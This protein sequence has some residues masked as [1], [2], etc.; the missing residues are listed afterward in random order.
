MLFCVSGESGNGNV[1]IY[2]YDSLTWQRICLILS[3]CRCRHGSLHTMHVGS[4]YITLACSDI[5]TIHTMTH[6]GDLVNVMKT[7]G[8][9]RLCHTGSDAVLVAEWLNNHL[10]LQNNGDW[11]RVL[12]KPPPLIPRDAVYV[13]GSLFVLSEWNFAIRKDR[14]IKYIRK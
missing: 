9:P 7:N 10:M 13:G 11:S 2:V 8:Y 1:V 4:E 14:I 3:P 6:A 12:L 5:N